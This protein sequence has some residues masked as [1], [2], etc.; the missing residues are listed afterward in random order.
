M[1][2]PTKLPGSCDARPIP[3]PATQIPLATQPHNQFHSG[4]NQQRST[5]ERETGSKTRTATSTIRDERDDRRRGVRPLLGFL[6][7]AVGALTHRLY[8]WGRAESDESPQEWN[9]ARKRGGSGGFLTSSVELLP[10]VSWVW[11]MHKPSVVVVASAGCSPHHPVYRKAADAGDDGD[12]PGGL[13]ARGALI[14]APVTT[15]KTCHATRTNSPHRDFNDGTKFKHEAARRAMRAKLPTEQTRLLGISYTVTVGRQPARPSPTQQV[16][17]RYCSPSHTHIEQVGTAFPKAR[18]A[19]PKLWASPVTPETAG[20]SCSAPT[21]SGTSVEREP[22]A[23]VHG[24]HAAGTV[25]FQQ[26]PPAST[27]WAFN[28]HS[29]FGPAT[30]PTEPARDGLVGADDAVAG[31]TWSEVGSAAVM[32]RRRRRVVPSAAAATASSGGG[33][34]SGAAAPPTVDDEAPVLHGWDERRA[35]GGYPS[36]PPEASAASP[37]PKTVSADE[38][39][40]LHGWDERRPVGGSSSPPPPSSKEQEEPLTPELQL[41]EKR[42]TLSDDEL[43][44]VKFL[45]G[46]IPEL[47]AVVGACGGHRSPRWGFMVAAPRSVGPRAASGLCSSGTTASSS[48]MAPSGLAT[49]PAKAYAVAASLSPVS[50]LHRLEQVAMP[51]S[52][53]VIVGSQV[54]TIHS[55]EE[56][57]HAN[58]GVHNKMPDANAAVLSSCVLA[59]AS[60]PAGSRLSA[61]APCRHARGLHLPR[62]PARA[63]AAPQGSDAARP[64][65]TSSGAAGHDSREAGIAADLPA[66]SAAE[67]SSTVGS[68]VSSSRLGFGRDLDSSSSGGVRGLVRACCGPPPAPPLLLFRRRCGVGLLVHSMVVQ[69]TAEREGAAD[70]DP[71]RMPARPKTRFVNDV[72]Q[73]QHGPNQNDTTSIPGPRPASPP[74]PPPR[75]PSSFL[76]STEPARH[77]LVDADD[78]PRRGWSH[79]DQSTTGSSP[80]P[81]L[82]PPAVAAA[83]AP[84]LPPLHYGRRQC[85]STRQSFS[86]AGMSVGRWKA[87]PRPRLLHGRLLQAKKKKSPVMP[88]LLLRRWTWAAAPCYL[89]AAPH[90]RK[91]PRRPASPV[92][93]AARL[94]CSRTWAAPSLIR[95]EH[96]SESSSE[97]TRTRRL[98]DFT[99][100]RRKLRDDATRPPIRR[101]PAA[102]DSPPVLRPK[103]TNP[104]SRLRGGFMENPP[105][106]LSYPGFEAKPVKPSM[107]MRVRPP[108][109]ATTPSSSFTPPPQRQAYSTLAI[110]ILLDLTDAIFTMYSCSSVHHASRPSTQ[111]YSPHPS[112]SWSFGLNLSSTAQAYSCSAFT[113]VHQ[114]DLSHLTFTTHRRPP[115]PAAKG[116]NRW[117]QIQRFSAR[118]YVVI[119]YSVGKSSQQSSGSA[120]VTTPCVVLR[121]SLDITAPPK[122]SVQTQFVLHKMDERMEKDDERWDHVMENMDLLF[123]QVGEI[124]SNQQKMQAQITMNTQVLEQMLADQQLLSK[125]IES[126]G[127]AVAKLT[128]NPRRHRRI[129][130]NIN[131]R[132]VGVLQ[133]FIAPLRARIRSACVISRRWPVPA[134]KGHNKP[135]TPKL[136][137]A[138]ANELIY[139]FGLAQEK[140]TLSDDELLLVKSLLGKITILEAVVGA[141]AGH[142]SPRWGFMVAAPVR[143]AWLCRRNALQRAPPP[144]RPSSSSEEHQPLTPAEIAKEVISRLTSLVNFLEDRMPDLEAASGVCGGVAPSPS[145]VALSGRG[146]ASGKASSSVWLSPVSTLRRP[147]KVATPAA[148]HATVGPQVVT[149]LSAEEG[150]HATSGVHNISEANASHERHRGQELSSEHESCSSSSSSSSKEP[151]SPGLRLE[152]AKQM[153]L[154]FTMAQ[155]T[156]M[157]S[158]QEHSFINFLEDR[159]LELEAASGMRGGAALSE[160]KVAP[161]GL[162]LL[163]RER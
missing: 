152:V 6:C 43:S 41:V 31:P 155:Q 59:A 63:A 49:V 122:P 161:S 60:P 90:G 88:G 101:R 103:P 119:Q 73:Q 82:L 13:N 91:A 3:D 124:G 42:R 131:I 14:K 21:R 33:C 68:S 75:R 37:R 11:L 114:H 1:S 116:H 160:S 7:A 30:A 17:T 35:V 118:A 151:L 120:G 10:V 27:P 110:A 28:S 132:L 52:A 97:R 139:R 95:D 141:S 129:R 9:G 19:D 61:C 150:A 18:V 45:L 8:G 2:E 36:P 98:H 81:P 111:A 163:L 83:S 57:A 94:P 142:H 149:R 79:A 100:P 138:V 76:P 147:K 71:T 80:P 117:Y 140:R 70:W 47:E 12:R 144:R 99:S 5:I 133:G 125:Q 40:V 106:P 96:A 115:L 15:H 38:A 78:A 24:V 137:L 29:P 74:P 34:C 26:R 22:A 51:A 72:Q 54:I 64:W 89:P 107:S 16:I 162:V 39:V 86:T 130:V 77:G 32:G 53:Y 23:A 143:L 50:T 48:K 145:K 112:P 159:I 127:Q 108:P 123:A 25:S 84:G 105:K 126:T 148:A 157:L 146:H 104:S 67:Q 69:P 153:I 56:D 156:R 65:R 55:G 93:W 20:R 128:L 46:T 113:M 154:G 58:S 158:A 92:A 4:H 66:G 135:L 87:P 102:P 109:S 134:A 85:F 136:Q 62:K 121:R 44:L